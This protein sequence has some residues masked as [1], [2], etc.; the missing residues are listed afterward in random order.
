MT[1]QAQCPRQLGAD[2]LLDSLTTV[3]GQDTAQRL[4]RSGITGRRLVPHC[5]ALAVRDIALTVAEGD[6]RF[7]ARVEQLA[8]KLVEA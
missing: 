4:D 7:I 8:R 5:R 6:K 2:R 3:R 1:G